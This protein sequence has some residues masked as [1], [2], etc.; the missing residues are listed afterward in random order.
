MA[1][2]P[3]EITVQ[4][5]QR[6]AAAG[7]TQ[8]QK[9]LT[10][11]G[12]RLAW[13]ERGGERVAAVRVLLMGD[14]GNRYDPNAIAVTID[15]KVVGYIPKDLTGKVRKAVGGHTGKVAMDAELVWTGDAYLVAFPA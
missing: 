14:P 10:K 15:G 6:F 1:R 13:S 11:A 7:T 4:L 9:A 8:Y 5:G 2:T 12:K 3:Q